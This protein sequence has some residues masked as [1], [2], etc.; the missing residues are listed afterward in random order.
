MT[1]LASSQSCPTRLG[2]R[3]RRLTDLALT[4]RTTHC[5]HVEQRCL[6]V[7]RR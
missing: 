3:S 2:P 7:S 1:V 5:V 6:R 4:W